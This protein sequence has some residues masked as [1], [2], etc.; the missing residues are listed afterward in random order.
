MNEIPD[1]S[2]TTPQLSD[3]NES[4]VLIMV[5]LATLKIKNKKCGLEVFKVVKDLLETDLVRESFNECHGE[6]ISN[7]SVKHN[8]INSR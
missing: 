5:T 7:K 8:K 4:E 2:P 6:L 1:R 3:G